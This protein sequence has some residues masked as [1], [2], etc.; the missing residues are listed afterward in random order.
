M[1]FM[2]N[3][4]TSLCLSE[5][6]GYIRMY[7]GWSQQKKSPKKPTWEHHLPGLGKCHRLWCGYDH[8]EYHVPR[9]IMHIVMYIYILYYHVQKC[10][11]RFTIVHISYIYVYPLYIYMSYLYNSTYPS[12][13]SDRLTV[14]CPAVRW[15]GSSE[16]QILKNIKSTLTI[17]DEHMAVFIH[18][19]ILIYIYII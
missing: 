16:F 10:Y 17:I 18:Y 3:C 7:L 9:Q 13:T 8:Y 15:G 14:P 5:C 11:Y 2:G 19:N 4:H 12:M 1:Q 6:P